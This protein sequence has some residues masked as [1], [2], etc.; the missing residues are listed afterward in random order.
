MRRAPYT[1]QRPTVEAT[2]TAS[3]RGGKKMWC[4]EALDEE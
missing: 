2:A 3:S 1:A 4:I